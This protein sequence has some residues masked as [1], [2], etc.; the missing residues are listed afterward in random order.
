MVH[1]SD[2]VLHK[3]S[4]IIYFIRVL[5]NFELLSYRCGI[6]FS[7]NLP[8][9]IGSLGPMSSHGQS[10]ITLFHIV[11]GNHKNLGFSR[12]IC[13]VIYVKF[14][15]KYFCRTFYATSSS[16]FDYFCSFSETGTKKHIQRLFID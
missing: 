9:V 5:S 15:V 3:V 16:I 12:Y 2:L 10:C 13:S 4:G 11:I 1:V 6:A 14:C 8:S 7:C